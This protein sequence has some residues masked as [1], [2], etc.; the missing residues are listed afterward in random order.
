MRHG[1][2][3]EELEG[4]AMLQLNA[5][6][7][8]TAAT[9]RG[10]LLYVLATPRVYQRLKAEI[11][12]AIE[13]KRVSS[14]IKYAEALQLPYL[15]AVI[16]EGYRIRCPVPYGHYK[17]VPPGGD[18]IKGLFGA[19]WHRHRPQ[20]ARSHPPPGHLRSRRRRLPARALPRG[21]TRPRRPR[22]TAPS[23]SPLGVAAGSA[24]VRLSLSWR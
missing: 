7:D 5:G 17:T 15:Q 12:T 4:E 10:T 8:T 14:P 23:T 16:W 1:L 20:H 18:T 21:A 19:R 6:A 22:W 13:Q 11:A 9:I 2:T 24:L 3:R